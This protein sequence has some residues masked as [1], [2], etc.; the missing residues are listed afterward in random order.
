MMVSTIEPR[1]NHTRLI[2]AW[3]LIRTTVDPDLRLVLVGRPGWNN[4]DVL[5]AMKPFQ[6]SGM[7]FNV[8]R[9]AGA[10]LGQLYRG[11]AAVV[12][13][14]I[15]EGFDLSGVEAIAAGGA[16]APS[17]IPV[18]REIYRDACE[19]FSPYSTP[20]AA[21]A[22]LRIIAKGNEARRAALVEAGAGIAARYRRSAIAP[23]WEKLFE[24]IAGA[25]TGRAS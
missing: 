8:S 7:L 15:A 19:Y 21:A 18:H 25:R 24:D 14:S 6:E 4:A 17:D 20:E 12:C 3:N 1:K 2:A 11:A 16:V 9:L 13:P 5:S 22:I 23:M 10:E